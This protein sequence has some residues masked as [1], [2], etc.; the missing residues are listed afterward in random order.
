M[1]DPVP[2]PRRWLQFRLRSL[3]LLMLVFPLLG[4]W[5][6]FL[7]YGYLREHQIVQGDFRGLG[8]APQ[9]P[10]W[11]RRL[12]GE[13]YFRRAVKADLCGQHSDRLTP[14]TL[15]EFRYLRYVSATGDFFTDKELALLKDLPDLEVLFLDHC[16]ITNAGLTHISELRQLKRL[17]LGGTQIRE[18][19]LQQLR[20]LKNLVMLEL[21]GTQATD[22][23][24][25]HLTQLDQLSSLDLSDTQIT[26]A[27]LQSISELPNL[28]S[29]TLWGTKISDEALQAFKQ[30]RPKVNVIP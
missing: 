18:P 3:L 20:H 15:V 4:T 2:R 7:R 25:R 12:C 27:G 1:N 26:D 17:K 8:T 30:A 22:E 13:K 19:N 11:I 9:G 21:Q 5:W 28:K 6:T 14:Q 24:I 16:Q 29:L 23:Q 10:E